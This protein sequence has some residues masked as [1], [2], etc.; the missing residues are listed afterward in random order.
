[1]M[2]PYIYCSQKNKSQ[3]LV[4]K[5]R[6]I[7]PYSVFFGTTKSVATRLLEKG[8]FFSLFIHNLVRKSKF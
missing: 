1:M 3:E 6:L 4:G 5:L 8:Q 7:F 2:T